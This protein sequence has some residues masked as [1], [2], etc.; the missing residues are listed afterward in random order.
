MMTEKW[1]T[2]MTLRAAIFGMLSAATFVLSASVATAEGT[3]RVGLEA[4]Y[5]PFAS[6]AAD[7]SL[8]GFDVEIAKALCEQMKKECQFIESDWDGII[9]ALMTKRFDAIISSMGITEERMKQVDFTGRYYYS[10]AALIVAKDSTVLADAEATSGKSIGVQRGTSH[11]CFVQKMFPKAE[12]KQYATTE[13][14]YL[15]LTAGRLDAV[16]VDTIPGDDW[17][18]NNAKNGEYKAANA[19]LYDEGCFGEG[20]GIAIRKGDGAL[21]DE[22]NAAIK[23]IRDSG[24]YQKISNAYFGRDIYGPE[25]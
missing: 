21:R 23:G 5:P 11:E 8:Q 16:L 14:I 19:E 13:E 12:M 22:L 18:K 15:D 20:V 10:P 6:K 4:A 17:L 2:T 24:A 1:E 3:L 25:K 9:P 7:G